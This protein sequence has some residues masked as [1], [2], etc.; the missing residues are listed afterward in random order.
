MAKFLAMALGHFQDPIAMENVAQRH[1]LAGTYL[2]GIKV[3][4][5]EIIDGSSYRTD[6]MERHWARDNYYIF[7]VA[8]WINKMTSRE[9]FYPHP[10][11]FITTVSKLYNH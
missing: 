2:Y 6:G 8:G 5:R 1:L 7:R 10:G 3:P 4:T 9:V 11:M